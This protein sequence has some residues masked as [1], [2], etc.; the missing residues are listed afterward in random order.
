MFQAGEAVLD[1]AV[2]LGALDVQPDAAENRRIDL[3]FQVDLFAGHGFQFLLQAGSLLLGQSHR[4]GGRRLE[5]AVSRIVAD[6]V[7]TGAAGQ[8]P[9][10]ALLA[11][12]LEEV[13]QIG[14]DLPAKRFVQQGAAF[15]FGDAGDAQQMQIGGGILEDRCGLVQLAQNAGLQP[16][17]RCQIVQAY[18]VHLC[19]LGHDASPTFLMNSSIR[20]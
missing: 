11:E 18:A 1:G 12:D 8:L 19:D 10:G 20:S 6:P 14:V 9:Q 2:K 13:E 15:L 17:L 3:G 4:R 16:F 7:R 5:D